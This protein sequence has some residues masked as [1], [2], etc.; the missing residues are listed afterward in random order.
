MIKVSALNRENQTV[1]L[2]TAVM[3]YHSAYDKDMAFLF[4]NIDFAIKRSNAWLENHP[5]LTN[6]KYYEVEEVLTEIL[7][8]DYFQSKAGIFYTLEAAMENTKSTDII[9][10]ITKRRVN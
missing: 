1:W 3:S 10:K 2:R 8:E 4:E 7:I 6:I 5:S 9:Y